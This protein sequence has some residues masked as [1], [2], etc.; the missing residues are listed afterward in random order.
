MLLGSGELCVCDLTQ[1]LQLSQPK[2][3]KHL[4]VLR[5]YG[6][7]QTRRDGLWMYYRYHA[8]LPAW[9]LDIF[10]AAGRASD[11]GLAEDQRRL[12]EWKNKE[13]HCPA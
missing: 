1:A 10:D 7:V 8:E 13:N 9:V 2:I 4:A 3:S 5:E 11:P 6:L 12:R